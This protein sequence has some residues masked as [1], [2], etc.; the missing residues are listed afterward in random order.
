M[1]TYTRVFTVTNN[2]LDAFD[3]LRMS[4]IL[5]ISQEI[6]G[7]HAN[8]L[9]VG[10]N[11]FKRRNLI[12]IILR[13]KVEVIKNVT[14]LKSVMCVTNLVKCR[15]FEFPR[16]YLFYQGDELIIK[17]RS[18]WAIY[19]LESKKVI[20]PSDIKSLFVED[21]GYFDRVRKLPIIKKE[22][23]NFFKEIEVTFSM[24]DHN[25]HMNNTRCA[26]LFLDV[27][28][29]SKDEKIKSFQIEYVSQ[30]FLNDKISLFTKIE[31]NVK[32]LYGY[33]NDE[34]KFYMAVEFF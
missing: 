23:L 27:F 3:N 22:E 28:K 4:S 16:D 18:I 31:N 5:D 1:E 34:L 14:D 30:S 21:I 2:M 26:D 9:N 33:N 17:A 6:A 7:D 8:L 19:D 11:E 13:N 29:L 25:G 32:Y 24:L 15:F 12:W 20:I 10:Y